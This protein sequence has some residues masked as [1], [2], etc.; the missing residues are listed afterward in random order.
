MARLS[1]LPP[2][3]L[4]GAATALLL[5]LAPGAGAN[6][7]SG[8]P[9]LP[10]PHMNG[11]SEGVPPSAMA[12]DNAE[13]LDLVRVTGTVFLSGISDPTRNDDPLRTTPEGVAVAVNAAAR[14]NASLGISYSPWVDFLPNY[15]LGPAFWPPPTDESFEPAVLGYFAENVARLLSGSPT[16]TRRWARVWPC[17][18]SPSTRK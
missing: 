7:F 1:I 13:W 12:L 4:A 3:F 8:L 2:L 16:P 15:S 11:F 5:L 17:A 10:I 6:V 18:G 14:F 9:A